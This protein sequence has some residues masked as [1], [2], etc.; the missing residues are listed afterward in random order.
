M[1]ELFKIN[2][3]ELEKVGIHFCLVILGFIATVLEA[4]IL[5]IIEVPSY[6][7]PFIVAVNTGLVSVIRTFIKNSEGK[8]LTTEKGKFLGIIKL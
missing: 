5:K 4:D 8:Y 3:N 6:L 7:L 2:K 1:S